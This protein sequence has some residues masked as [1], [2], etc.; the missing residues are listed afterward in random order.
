MSGHTL[1][2]AVAPV[3]L[4]LYG[5]FRCSSCFQFTE[6][7]TEQQ[8]VNSYVTTGKVKIVW[9]DYTVVDEIQNNTATFDTGFS[10]TSEPM[11]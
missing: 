6:D 1:G 5:D 8:L 7:G 2:R 11:N 3:T 4:D 10:L 9:H